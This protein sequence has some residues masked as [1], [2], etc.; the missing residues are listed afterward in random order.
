[1][2]IGLHVCRKI[3]GVPNILDVIITNRMLRNNLG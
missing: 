2:S 1:M 3:N